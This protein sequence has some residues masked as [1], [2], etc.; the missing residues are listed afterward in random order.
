[1]GNVALAWCVGHS[2]ASIP[3]KGELIPSG[4]IPAERM[5]VVSDGESH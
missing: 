4:L 2:A 3:E 5:G 1:M